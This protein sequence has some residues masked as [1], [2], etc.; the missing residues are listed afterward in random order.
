M[1]KGKGVL[2]RDSLV[3]IIS[4]GLLGWAGLAFKEIYFEFISDM[5]I[6]FASLNIPPDSPIGQEAALVDESDCFPNEEKR[7]FAGENGIPI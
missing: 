4:N 2:K 1:D 5:M 3:V 7:R 6:S